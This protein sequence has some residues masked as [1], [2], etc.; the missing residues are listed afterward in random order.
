MLSCASGLRTLE[1]IGS[2]H[3]NAALGGTLRK[4]EPHHRIAFARELR[5]ARADA[6]K[7]AEEFD[8]ILF[9]FERLGSFLT[10][11]HRNLGSYKDAL[12]TIA[13]ETPL[14]E[15][16]A[17]KFPQFHVRF[18]VLYDEVR[19]ARNDAMHQGVAARHLTRNAQELALAMEEALMAGA[20]TAGE[21]MVP[22]PMCAELWHPLTDVRRA[23]LLNSFSFLPYRLASGEWRLVSD[24]RMVQ[25]LR[26]QDGE[27][28]DRLLMTLEKAIERGL[29]QTVPFQCKLDDPIV[30]IAAR[31]SE[32]P[33][34]VMS[35]DG[36]LAGIITAFDLL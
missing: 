2:R 28:N 24:C 18:S 13:I 35:D 9:V 32:E 11:A 1:E 5:S 23:M 22:K 12:C 20:K 4:L 21:I 31:I 6:L 26:F 25:F 36:R 33:C 19:A 29:E 16:A 8:Q 3:H 27:R 7:N 14:F 30:D 10:E 17:K 34:L 15:V